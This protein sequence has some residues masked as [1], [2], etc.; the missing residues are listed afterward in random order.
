MSGHAQNPSEAPKDS[1]HTHRENWVF[2]NTYRIHTA[3]KV[4][5]GSF[6]EIFR[7]TDV[8]TGEEV[9]VKV[10]RTSARQPQLVYESRIYRLLQG[11]PG[12]PNVKACQPDGDVYVMV[13][14]LLGP[15]LEDVFSACNRRF[16][17][18]TTCQLADQL[19][20]RVEHLH[21]KNFIH[22][23]IKPD[24]FLLGRGSTQD[25]VYMIDFGLAKR[26]RDPR[27]HQHIPSRETKGITGTVRYAS[28]NTHMGIEQSRRD[29][30]ES[31]GYVFLYFLLGQLPW[32]GIKARSRRQKYSKIGEIKMN[33]PI[34]TL[35]KRV[36]P[37][38]AT[39]LNSVRRLLHPFP[40]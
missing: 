5:S 32:Q 31:L 3:Q 18:T 27:T 39:Y 33:T 19:L 2:L 6:G 22:R 1:G 29:D 14:D 26:Y 34:E 20:S 35:C 8:N 30:L 24:N 40:L 12:I 4:G 9:A 25:V 38:F 11:E 7:A 37:E 21:A 13:M 16:S 36:A 17:I 23:D 28:I 10:E 15:S